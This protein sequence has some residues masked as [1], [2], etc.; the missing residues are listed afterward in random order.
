MNLE[1]LQRIQTAQQ[2]TPE[3]YA[4]LQRIQ[5][6]IKYWVMRGRF[7]CHADSDTCHKCGYGFFA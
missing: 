2:P 6:K 5:E 7:E 1:Q 3:E 4:E